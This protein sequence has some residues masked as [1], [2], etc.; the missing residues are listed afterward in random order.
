MARH[1]GEL[2]GLQQRKISKEELLQKL[3][4]AEQEAAVSA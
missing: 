1:L 3:E 4:H 2:F